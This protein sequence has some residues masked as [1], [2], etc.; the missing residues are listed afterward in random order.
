N[1]LIVTLESGPVKDF[2]NRIRI[3][4]ADFDFT[5]GV[6]DVTGTDPIETDPTVM[7]SWSDDGGVNF[8]N[9]W[10]RKLGKQAVSTQRIT[11]LNTGLSGPMGR[12]WRLSVSDPVHFGF[13]GGDQKAEP[14]V[15]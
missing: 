1:P 12:R 10:N 15:G 3:A 4:R 2:P 5:V 14:R 7:V 8:T 13:L 6:G 11:T 9:P